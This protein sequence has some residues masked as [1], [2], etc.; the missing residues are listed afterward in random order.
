MGKTS[1]HNSKNLRQ[2][3]RFMVKFASVQFFWGHKLGKPILK[4]KS[5]HW[6]LEDF[7]LYR[8]PM[9]MFLIPATNRFLKMVWGAKLWTP[10]FLCL[11]F[12]L[13]IL[14]CTT[15]LWKFF[16][17][18]PLTNFWKWFAARNCEIFFGLRQGFHA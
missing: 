1:Q 14:V 4:P 2:N 10:M 5:L 13:Q 9:K 18:V 3:T 17:F 12:D 15:N 16:R 7:I 6:Q 11:K 8:E